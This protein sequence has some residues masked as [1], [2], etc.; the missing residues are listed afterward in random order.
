MATQGGLWQAAVLGF[1]GLSLGQDALQFDPHLPRSWRSLRFPIQWR[2]RLLRIEVRGEP[3]RFT[4]TLL[5]G[6]P[7]PLRV[8]AL[9]HQLSVN[10]TW[11]CRWVES[12]MRWVQVRGTPSPSERGDLGAP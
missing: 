5:E 9:V 2:G 7:M 11:S 3:R 12:R 6:E 4:A 1:A 10:E 8:G